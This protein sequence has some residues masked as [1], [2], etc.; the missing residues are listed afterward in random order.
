MEDIMGIIQNND[1]QFML[2]A[3]FIIAIGLVITTVMFSSIIF[4][5]NMAI[6]GGSDPSKNEL[7]NLIHITKDETRAAYNNST[8]SGG[9]NTDKF[10]N[11]SKQMQY[12]NGNLSKMYAL[13]GE[14]VNISWENWTNKGY[15]NLT[16]NGTANGVSNWTVI[17][18]VKNSN[19]TVDVIYFNGAF[20]IRLKNSTEKL[21]NIT[22]TGTFSFINS[23]ANDPYSIAFVN[24]A[25]ASGRFNMTGNASGKQFIRARD[26]VINTTMTFSSNRIKTI[27][28][29]PFSV[30]W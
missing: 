3:G 13:H 30:P 20:Q 18:N 2:L 21:I 24:G 17:E 4:E 16:D 26:Y 27:L 14:T 11:F 29:I 22:S 25:N 6:G 12:F 15:A 5:E 9:G 7:V 19:I 1:A 8:A 10:N 28:T 23:T